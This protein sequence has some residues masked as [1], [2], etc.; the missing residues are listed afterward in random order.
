MA[1]AIA[2][3]CLLCSVAVSLGSSSRVL[4]W[5]TEAGT[6]SWRVVSN[7]GSGCAHM[8]GHMCAEGGVI[9][10]HFINTVERY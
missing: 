8:H 2:A 7:E 9:E 10:G 6:T 4:L 5:A 3:D 1:L